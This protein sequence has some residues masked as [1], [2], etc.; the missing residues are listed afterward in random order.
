MRRI[1]I[2]DQQ[3]DPAYLAASLDVDTLHG[4]LREAESGN[5]QR[6]FALYRDV[7]L[8]DSHAQTEFTK[9]KLAVLGDVFSCL[10]DDKTKTE[11]C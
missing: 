5:P 2:Y 4:I 7:I 1:T 9:R 6:L 10:P 8:S 11:D 3:Q